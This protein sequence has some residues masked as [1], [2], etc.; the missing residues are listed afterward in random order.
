MKIITFLLS[1]TV[2]VLTT[3]CSVHVTKNMSEVFRDVEEDIQ[4]HNVKYMKSKKMYV[5]HGVDEKNLGA[6]KFNF[7]F[8][9]DEADSG[10]DVNVFDKKEWD[11][12][13]REF[14]NAFAAT[15]RF[16]LGQLNDVLS[17]R[18]ARV[19]ANN[20]VTRTKEL[21]VSAMSEVGGLLHIHP[22]LTMTNSEKKIGFFRGGGYSSMSVN[23]MKT[24]CDPLYAEN[25]E[26]VDAIQSFS[27][28][29]TGTIYQR[30]NKMRVVTRGIVLDNSGLY[31]LHVMQMRAS[32][33]KFFLKIYE[34]F[35]VGGPVV[36]FDEDDNAVIRASRSTGVQPEMEFVIYAMKKADGDAAVRVPLFNATAVSVGQTGNTTLKIWRKNSEK[37][38]KK[39]IKMINENFDAAKAEYDFYGCS[40]GLAKWPDFVQRAFEEED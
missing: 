19:A 8:G 37:S 32:I 34:L 24:T 14:V 26:Q 27:V 39:I 7:A 31:D 10:Y 6:L 30:K 35:P 1:A 25:N 4:Y 16:P 12:Y 18:D 9:Q 33:V 29:V 13:K 5:P 11:I 15:K 36:N 17:D 3:S 28:Q 38:A 22:T 2:A 23:T 20:G 21:D 40:D